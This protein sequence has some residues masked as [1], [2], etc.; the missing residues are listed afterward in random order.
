MSKIVKTILGIFILYLL[1]LNF[2]KAVA[3]GNAVFDKAYKCLVEKN[4]TININ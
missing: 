1:W 2:D 3:I 4:D